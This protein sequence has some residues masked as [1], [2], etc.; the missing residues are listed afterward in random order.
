MCFC[1]GSDS[2]DPVDASGGILIMNWPPVKSGSRQIRETCQKSWWID[3]FGAITFYLL[4]S[5][6]DFDWDWPLESELK[7][8]HLWTIQR[9]HDSSLIQDILRQH[10]NTSICLFIWSTTSTESAPQRE[11]KRL[12]RRFSDPPMIQFPVSSQRCLPSM[13]LQWVPGALCLEES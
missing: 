3:N 1:G 10:V 4:F 11:V 5:M 2:S 6:S 13:E 7:S 12:R 8:L 9:G